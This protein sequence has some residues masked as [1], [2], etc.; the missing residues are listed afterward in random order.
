MS[1]N[2]KYANQR[3]YRERHPDRVRE[4]LRKTRAKPE[5]KARIREYERQR[6]VQHRDRI[7]E[8][9]H[10]SR[11]KPEVQAKRREYNRIYRQTH[12]AS[13]DHKTANRLKQRA[14]RHEIKLHLV[15]MMGG[16]CWRCGWAEHMFG[17]EF[18][19][20]DPILKQHVPSDLI[21]RTGR[22]SEAERYITTNCIMLCA[23]CHALKTVAYGDNLR[24]N[25]ISD[26]T[27]ERL[28]FESIPLVDPR[29]KSPMV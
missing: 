26:T 9:Q 15:M 3:R 4:T 19:H 20:R 25:N 12:P 16:K 5:V 28:L 14:L 1:S 23:N 7:Q 11:A 18:D 8:L 13:R 17:L 21:S 6:Y 2:E 24:G 22:R 29:I 27:E 10:R